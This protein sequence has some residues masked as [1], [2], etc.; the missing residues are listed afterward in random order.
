MANNWSRL[1]NPPPPL[2]LGKKER[3]LVKQVNTELEERI[4]G[5]QILYYPLD[6]ER[7]NYHPLYGEAIE[8]VYLPPVHVYV[9]V[10][11]EGSS[12]T[13]D[14][15]GLDRLQTITLHFH[16]RRLT[17]DQNLYVSEG[18]IISYGTNYF[19]ITELN[20]PTEIFGQNKYKMEI[21]AKC[22][23]VT[24]GFFNGEQ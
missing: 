24:Q 1:T 4:I 23:K 2:F 9:L 13:S 21:S 7:S 6:I 10:D 5:Q 8:K 18:D 17:E 20:E 15:F 19:E 11:W 22:R 16:S 12:T 14:Q 3:D